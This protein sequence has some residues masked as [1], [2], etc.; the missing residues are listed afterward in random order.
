[1]GSRSGPNG[2]VN[3]YMLTDF[4]DE[5]LGEVFISPYIQRIST[6]APEGFFLKQAGA[7]PR[8]L[9]SPLGS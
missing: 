3:C 9:S 4:F 6:R 7:Y 8:Q 1:M 5:P 2:L